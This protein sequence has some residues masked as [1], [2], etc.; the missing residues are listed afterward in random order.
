M[1]EQ[2][3]QVVA[4]VEKLSEAEQNAI[5]ALIERELL[6]EQ[7]W[8]DLFAD[9]RSDRALDDLAGEALA[10]AGRGETQPLKDLL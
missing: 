2:F 7:K 1:T 5:A 4:Q 9:P 6:D 10:E 8:D 3:R